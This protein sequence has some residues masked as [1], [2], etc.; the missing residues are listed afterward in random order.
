MRGG[1]VSEGVSADHGGGRMVAA[2]ASTAEV[3][4]S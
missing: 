3:D 2:A 1:T 4:C